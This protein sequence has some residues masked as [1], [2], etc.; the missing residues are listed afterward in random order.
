MKVTKLT[1]TNI[2]IVKDAAIE[3]NKPEIVFYGDIK[4]GKSTLLNAV[5]W[6][7]GGAFPDDI[8]RHGQIEASAQLEGTETDGKP[9]VIRREWYRAKDGAATARAISYT[10]NGVPVKKPVDAIKAHLNPYLLD[11]DY[12]RRMTTLERN[13]Y[14]TELFGVDTSEDDGIIAETERQ[15]SQ[16]RIKVK[17]YGAL[18]LTPVT[19][20]DVEKI[21]EAR[22]GIV[23]HHRRKVT[24]AQDAIDRMT[25]AYDAAVSEVDAGNETAR[26]HNSTVERGKESLAAGEKRVKELKKEL[27]DI[28]AKCAKTRDWLAMNPVKALTPKPAAP[29]VS[30]YRAITATQPDTSACDQALSE[31]GATN[32]KADNYEAAKKKAADKAKDE[33]ALT[34]QERIG[35]EA[36]AAKV[37]RL[38]TVGSSTGIAGLVFK[39]G[40]FDFDG[41]DSSMLSDSQLM[42]L[43]D[44]LSAKYPEGFGLSMIDRGESLGKSVLTLWEDAQARSATVLVTVVGD[45]P[46]TIPEQVGA[47]VVTE[48]TVTP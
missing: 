7:C 39:D 47:Y 16:L 28:E 9:W 10:R 34:E 41:T 42:R 22:A 2:G 17:M 48:G 27:A 44:A 33:K 19:R 20:V 31:A 32:V 46:A 5:R 29:D 4:Q 11:Q 21:K 15:A 36:K 6:V 13:R 35:K 14:L 45:K 12:L 8:I 26:Y 23:E 25:E 18:D 38:A 37:K 43:S 30:E 24:S 3:I 40:G 1:V